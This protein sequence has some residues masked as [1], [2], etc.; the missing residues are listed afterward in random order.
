MASPA[1][2]VAIRE[3]EQ[4]NGRGLGCTADRH[5]EYGACD[6]DGAEC[7]NSRSVILSAAKNLT[8]GTGDASSTG[9]VRRKSLPLYFKG[10][11]GYIT[12]T[13]IPSVLI[14]FGQLPLVNKGSLQGA[15]PPRS[16]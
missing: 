2:R 6:D 9:C 4:R 15:E 3:E 1:Q 13:L 12:G 10:R 8:G 16:F 7:R 14:P 5:E 11:R